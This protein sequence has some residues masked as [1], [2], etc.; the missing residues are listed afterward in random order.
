[1]EIT[2]SWE[3]EGLKKGLKRE[4]ELVLR[5]I[6]KNFGSLKKI[7]EKQILALRIEKIEELGEA[8]F[9]FKDTDDLQLWL[10][11]VSPNN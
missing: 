2:T 5:L 9:D 10:N 8:I 11:Q 7:R 4:T 6:K 3:K 1:M